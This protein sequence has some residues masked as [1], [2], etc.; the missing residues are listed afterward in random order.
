MTSVPA[1]RSCRPRRSRP[2]IGAYDRDGPAHAEPAAEPAEVAQRQRE[3]DDEIANRAR[4][5]SRAA[6]RRRAAPLQCA[7]RASRAVR[8]Q[9]AVAADLV[10][11][12]DEHHGHGDARA[13]NAEDRDRDHGHGGDDDVV[14]E[15]PGEPA[16]RARERHAARRRS[17]RRGTR[18]PRPRGRHPGAPSTRRSRRPRAATCSAR[19]GGR[20]V[21]TRTGSPTSPTRR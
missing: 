11:R 14:D 6:R 12:V 16:R 4:R 19:R 15:E 18:P 21:P 1:A 13:A 3:R 2:R 10:H 8:P 20:R 9:I 7:R 17:S 5:G